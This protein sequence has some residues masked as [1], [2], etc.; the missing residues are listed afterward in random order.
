MIIT[1]GCAVP[2]PPRPPSGLPHPWFD[3]DRTDEDRTEEALPRA[4][5]TIHRR[6]VAINA[7]G[8][9]L[10][11]L[12]NGTAEHLLATPVSGRLTLGTLLCLLQLAVLVATAWLYEHHAQRT[13]PQQD[14]TPAHTAPSPT[15]E[16]D[17]A[18]GTETPGWAV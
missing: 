3:K 17:G 8:L 11:T 9:A 4:Q 10:M 14:R 1:R 12:L 7:G 16:R 2:L 13:G 18:S 5:T 6:F 15:A